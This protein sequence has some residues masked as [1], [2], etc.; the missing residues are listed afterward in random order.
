MFVNAH[1]ADKRGSGLQDK[2]LQACKKESKINFNL[3]P[4]GA[5]APTGLVS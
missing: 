2:I 3:Q 1:L 4:L 5:L